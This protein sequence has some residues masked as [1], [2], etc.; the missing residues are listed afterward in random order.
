MPL[1]LKCNYAVFQWRL[2]DVVDLDLPEVGAT[3]TFLI[4]GYSFIDI[5]DGGGIDLTL[6]PHLASDYAWDYATME[7][8]VP[9]VAKPNFEYA[10]PAAT[11]LTRA[12]GTF[13]YSGS[14]Q[15]DR[16]IYWSWNEP[17]WAILSHYELQV[18]EDVG[19]WVTYQV[20]EPTWTTEASPDFSYQARFRNVGLNGKK[21]GWSAISSV[22]V[23][24]DTTAPGNPTGMSVASGTAHTVN[25]TNP[26]D[27][28]FSRMRV[29]VAGDVVATVAGRP[30]SR[31]SAT[32]AAAA[33][34]VYSLQSESVDGALG[35]VV[36]A[37][38]GTT[39]A[40]QA[41]STQIGGAITPIN[42]SISDLDD[43]VTALESA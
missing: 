3:G 18:R 10:A 17:D 11:G 40:S 22:S 27:N 21:S 34:T 20:S 5:S 28:N 26:T 13:F 7:R 33:G 16:L 38:T 15:V 25:W 19:A 24:R 14:D 36:T 31:G 42:T 35:S 6:V 43:R 23:F 2:Y 1:I 4:V 30:G 39:N 32:F 12:V 37:G 9:T 8:L 29:I 41:V